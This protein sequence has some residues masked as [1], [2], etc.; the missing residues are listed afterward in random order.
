MEQ[1]QPQL[2]TSSHCKTTHYVIFM[3]TS[4]PSRCKS[5]PLQPQIFTWK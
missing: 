5:L 4:L 1:N 3:L 2:K